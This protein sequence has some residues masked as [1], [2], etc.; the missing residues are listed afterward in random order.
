MHRLQKRQV[1]GIPLT[2]T[3]PDEV[4]R[5]ICETAVRADHSGQDIHL[6]NA[7]SIALSQQDEEYRFCLLNASHNL[8]DG[9]PLSWLTR[10]SSRPLTQV[11]GPGL[12]ELVMDVGRNYGLKHF[13]LGATP[14]T[15][16]LL[17]SALSTR[18]PGVKI[19]GSYSPPFRPMSTKETQQQ[20]DQLVNSGAHVVWVGLGTPKQDVEVRRL[21]HDQN[22]FAIAVGAAFDFSAG[23]KKEAPSWLG[24][25]G[26]E[27]MFRFASEP[28]RLWRRYLIGNIV[29]LRAVIKDTVRK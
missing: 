16:N 4:A 29:F 15:L 9:K 11:R 18:Y 23:T 21:R 3:T 12:F 8:P 28:R 20:D 10:F 13:L 5:L 27:W 14:Q 2:I 6:V 1:A 25:I 19:V 26:L 7:Y 17:D 24:C 22:L